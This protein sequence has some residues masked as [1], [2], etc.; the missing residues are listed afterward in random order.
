MKLGLDLYSVRSQGWTPFEQLDYCK[1]L[2]L[3]VAHFGLES[4]QQFDDEHLRAVRDHA[5]DLGLE[6]E[7]GIGSIC[8]SQP[9]FR[10]ERGSA[11]EQARWGL[12]VASV[13]GSPIL[14]CLLG[15]AQAR[16][17]PTPLATHIANVVETC[18]AVRPVA[19][20]LGI[21]LAV[22]T[23][24]D[25]QGWEMRQLIEE[26]GPDYVGALLDAG[27]A[28]MLHE[29]PMVTLEHLALYNIASHFRDTVVWPHPSGAAVQGVA[30]GDGNVGIAE[31][32]AR[33]R[34]LCPEV[35]F[36]LEILTGSPPRVLNYLEPEYW[37]AFPQ[38]R[39]AEFARFERLVRR[40]L[41]FMGTMVTVARGET[42]PE[43]YAAALV[44]QQRY[45]VERSVRFCQDVL[46]MG[47]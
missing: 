3:N 28:L 16:R 2:G 14:R 43:E 21:K 42:T 44:A 25:L 1:R 39:A 23:H 22:E 36:V 40:G 5:A 18:R 26:A 27:N 30:M 24:G 7:F 33:Y 37:A 34:E 47:E 35:P 20:N 10:H 32:A 9:G 6:V 17:M 12:H 8:E 38:G 11:V 45:D 4:F 13:L 15:N 41:P 29:D 46:G 19:L 31:V